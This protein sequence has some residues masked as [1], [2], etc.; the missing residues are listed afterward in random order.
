MAYCRKCGKE[1]DDEAIMCVHC[2]VPTDLYNKKSEPEQSV[3][4]TKKAE[5]A[6]LKEEAEL[7]KEKEPGMYKT[8]LVLNWIAVIGI[9]LGFGLAFF[10]Y[11]LLSL[12][13]FI[14]SFVIM[15][16]GYKRLGSVYML[17]YLLLGIFIW[18]FNFFVLL[19]L[20]K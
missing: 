8:I 4:E 18:C 12:P 10:F 1:I 11:P 20:M 3:S 17:M 13:A 6:N 2:G 7:F 14:Y 19:A 15:S 9:G 5:P 16:K